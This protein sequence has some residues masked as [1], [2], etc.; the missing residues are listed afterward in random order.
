LSHSPFLPCPQGHSGLGAGPNQEHL[1]LNAICVVVNLGQGQI[2]L[3]YI[4]PVHSAVTNDELAIDSGG[5]S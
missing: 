1:G 4:A 5:Y 2:C 3:L